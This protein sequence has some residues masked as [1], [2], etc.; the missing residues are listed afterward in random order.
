MWRVL[1]VAICANFPLSAP[2][3]AGEKTAPPVKAEGPTV[4]KGGPPS[5]AA[6]DAWIQ[7]LGDARFSVR[8][9]AKRALLAAGPHA[10]AAVLQ[11][12]K[13]MDLE[14]KRRAEGLARQIEANAAKVLEGFGAS[15][16]RRA[17]GS[18]SKLDF[19]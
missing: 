8:E 17:N 15:L 3:L 9:A 19:Y 14:V 7:Q 1:A 2:S 18:V 12:A 4:P 10:M 11:A 6:I 16:E 13:S 5:K